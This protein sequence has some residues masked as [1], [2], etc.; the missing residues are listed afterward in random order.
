LGL[1]GEVAHATLFLASDESFY[2]TGSHLA[3]G[4]G[5]FG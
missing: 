2:T 1:P 3:C 5:A 4:G